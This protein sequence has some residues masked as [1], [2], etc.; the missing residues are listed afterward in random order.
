MLV[1]TGT[2]V[3]KTHVACALLAH[4]REAAV[5]AL[6]YKPVATGARGRAEDAL[7]HAEAGGHDYVAPTYAFEPPVSPHLAAREAGVEIEPARIRTRADELERRGGVLVVET[8]GG[9]FTPPNPEIVRA[10]LPAAVVLV[11]PDR[12]GVLHDVTACVR[13]A[14]VPIVAIALSAPAAPDA[15]TGTNARELLRLGIGNM[16]SIFPRAPWGAPENLE[17]AGELWRLCAA[18]A[19]T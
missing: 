16:F 6:G 19:A 2:D 3:G 7:A 15:S 4:L 14:D 9:L 1:G 13:A 10:L 8:A 11:A 5:P 12:L 17:I 18:A